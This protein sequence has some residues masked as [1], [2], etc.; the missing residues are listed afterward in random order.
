MKALLWKDYRVNRQVLIV[1]SCVLVAP[2][3][4]AVVWIWYDVGLANAPATMWGPALSTAAQASLIIS[5][6][7]ILLLAGNIIAGERRD[8][9]AEFL[10]YLP[11]PRSTILTSKAL[12]SLVVAVVIWGVYLLMAEVAIPAIQAE[13]SR[14]HREGFAL[15]RGLLLAIGVAVFGMAWLGSAMLESPTYSAAIG[16]FAAISVPIVLNFV[17]IATGFPEHGEP[18]FR[19][20][21][22]SLFALGVLGFVAG[23]CYYVRRVEP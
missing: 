6:L 2:Y 22:T 23:W 11:P 12:L 13:A 21:Q 7:T 19:W 18:Y 14:E 8:R 3:L 15:A 16:V 1:G 5:Q 10:A 20:L 9:S 17:S 4:T